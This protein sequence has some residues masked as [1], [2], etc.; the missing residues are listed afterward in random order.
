TPTPRANSS[1]VRN[2]LASAASAFISIQPF[3]ILRTI[4]FRACWTLLLATVTSELPTLLTLLPTAT[5]I[6][7]I[8]VQVPFAARTI[9]LQ[10]ERAFSPGPTHHRSSRIPSPPKISSRKLG[11]RAAA[12]RF[13]AMLSLHG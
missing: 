8:L 9:Q 4:S 3:R 12:K 10:H 2:R 1:C 5:A 11:S 7:T 6:A 13:L